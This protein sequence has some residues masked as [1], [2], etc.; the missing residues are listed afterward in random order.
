VASIVALV[1]ALASSARAQSRAAADSA[2][3]DSARVATR[4]GATVITATRLSTEG[5]ERAPARVDAV[6]VAR[7]A[8][9]PAA[10]ADAMARLPGVSLFD[11]QGTRAQP[12]LV[13]R[14]FTLSPVVGVAQGVSVFLDG[15]RVNEG[16]AQEVN[17]DLLPEDALADAR[18]VRGPSAVLGKNTLAGAL[19][20]ET[21]RGQ[22][23]AAL[24]LTA[25]G[26]SFGSRVARASGGLA[27]DG[28]DLFAAGHLA[29]EEGW[30]DATAAE[31]RSLFVTLGAR[32][33][34]GEATRSR[35]WRDA[36]LS[37]LLA[38]DSLQQAGSLPESWLP[39]RRSA[40]YTGGDYFA[41]V[42]AHI[43]LRGTRDAFGGALRG[44][45]YARQ[46]SSVQYN[47][48]GGDP[49]TR[50]A[51]RTRTVGATAELTR[52]ATLAARPLQ[53]TA[54]VEAARV[55]VRYRIRGIPN[56]AAPEL[57]PEECDVA[58]GL[59][60]SAR[61]REVDLAAFA[62]ATYEPIERVAI[63][64]AAR[65][66]WVRLPFED[67]REPENDG[68]SRFRQLSPSLGATWRPSDAIRAYASIGAGF[69]APA[70]LE[71]ACAD[72]EA[73][74]PLPFSL[75]DDP[76]LRPVRVRNIESGITWKPT[77]RLSLDLAAYRADVRDE[78]V[79]VASE[80][81]AGYFHN[82]A[83]TRRQGLELSAQLAP[84]R[85]IDVHAS[86][87][88]LDATYR[89]TERLASAL[90]GA[91][92]VRAGDAI[93]LSP[94]RRASAVVD[95]HTLAGPLLIGASLGASATSSQFLRGDDANVTAPLPGYAVASLRLSAESAHWRMVADVSN[96]F[97]RSFETFGIWGTNANATDGS[98]LP[99]G[100]RV[101]RFLTPGYPRTITLALTLRR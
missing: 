6:A 89:S 52:G 30:R 51:I 18:L 95:A 49:D 5:A 63:T 8:S 60:E 1:V 85:G 61:V 38:H 68:T 46:L 82:L 80:R 90:G 21:R 65:A 28:F 62:Q 98:P 74:C 86:Y 32:P 39:T 97:D 9:G 81:T 64:A 37:V 75:G 24:Q 44:N 10:V 42:L 76:P 3:R 48:N 27:R 13:V 19:S 20:L 2:A 87:A 58:S 23:V 7:A 94:R 69:R 16:D 66:D 88:L 14:G 22:P 15:V 99:G 67:L 57:D 55:G 92:S 83:R 35:A 11:D 50:A 45:L 71:L 26:G 34:D 43:A 72:P 47:V 17:F 25:E 101:E 79:L 54:G 70:A 53:L 91:D 100:A 33:D 93:P 12:T 41:P 59:C 29:R 31:R 96:L 4:L 36:A 78:I 73:P 56:I 40:N 77:A 84:A